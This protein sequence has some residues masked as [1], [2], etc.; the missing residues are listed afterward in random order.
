MRRLTA[1][2]AAAVLVLSACGD[3]SA[4]PVDLS[5]VNT[6]PADSG[7][8][9]TDN[10]FTFANYGASA[11]AEVFNED[12]LVQ[13][14]G[15][16]SCVDEKTDPC[17]ATTQA[18]AWAR[19]VNETRAVGHCEGLVVQ[20]SERFS[21]KATP[22]TSALKRSAELD[23]AIMRAFATQFLPEVEDATREWDD[24]SLGDVVNEL[25]KVLSQGQTPYVLGVTS[26][27]GGHAV[28][29]YAIDFPQKTLA[30]VKVYDPNWPSMERYVVIDLAAN[31]WYFSF[32]GR[33]P[34][35][36]TCAWTGG[37]GSITLT[38][39]EA[40]KSATCP[41]CGG[42]ST[43]TRNLL[44][45]RSASTAWSVTTEAGTYSPSSGENPD[46]VSARAIHTG[47]CSED[48]KLPEFVLSTE[49]TDFELTL[50]D[51][52]SVY[53]SNGKSVVHLRTKGSKKRKPVK[54]T[55]TSVQMDDNSTTLTVTQ[56]NLAAIVDVP[57]AS[58]AYDD[59]KITIAVTNNGKQEEVAV[60][61][62]QPSRR[63]EIDNGTIATS[64][65]S[66]Q[67][68][69]VTLKEDTAAI[70]PVTTTTVAP[71]GK[72]P[73]A[74]SAPVVTIPSLTP[75]ASTSSSTTAAPA[76]GS[77]ANTTATTLA[78]SGG[79]QATTPATTASTSTSTTTTT[80]FVPTIKL[81][82]SN[83]EGGGSGATVDSW[84]V[85][86]WIDPADPAQ[87]TYVEKRCGPAEQ[88]LCHNYEFRPPV[89]W[90]VLVDWNIYASVYTYK[91]KCPG[92][93]NWSTP[94]T[95][96]GGRWFMRCDFTSANNATI[97]IAPQ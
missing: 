61:P 48:N 26:D 24:K 15:A 45:I 35:S 56:N 82:I 23:H 6:T 79:T 18:A 44:V 21:L 16:T 77:P 19:M 39:M 93:S 52:S 81:S 65:A 73:A 29:P 72:S 62:Q 80:V 40:R 94:S 86:T 51:E 5:T 59:S 22:V 90:Q 13:M 1:L 36:D 2:V 28:L 31:K 69:A 43:V 92:D 75:T 95:Y 10:G 96:A 68:S 67:T 4:A 30:V 71:S 89:G 83:G 76:S 63:I 58:V 8:N 37:P 87:Q 20:A 33:D 91:Y 25:V 78:P 49:T 85:L 74:T 47:T 38:P 88:A 14:F 66:K 60:T 17:V 55:D 7:M 3:K 12:D 70:I 32:S 9:P 41:F 53:V 46:D 34:Q 11:S 27:I 42:K 84:G 64:D 57:V 97:Y 54:F 50:P